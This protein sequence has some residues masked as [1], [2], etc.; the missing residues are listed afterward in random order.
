MLTG[1]VCINDTSM[2]INKFN[3]IQSS[4][5]TVTMYVSVQ[6]LSGAQQYLKWLHLRKNSTRVLHNAGLRNFRCSSPEGAS[7]GLSASLPTLSSL[8]RQEISL[9]A[10]GA[11]N[12]ECMC[13]WAAYRKMGHR[14]SGKDIQG[15]RAKGGSKKRA[16]KALLQTVILSYQIKTDILRAS[17]V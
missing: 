6:F 17:E 14:S 7:S 10:R 2:S 9:G 15:W 1:H 13:I 8:W 4:L 16:N 3:S 5:P 11:V 12:D